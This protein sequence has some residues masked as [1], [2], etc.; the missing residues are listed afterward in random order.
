M[1]QTTIH[2]ST[3]RLWWWLMQAAYQGEPH[4]YNQQMWAWMRR[5]RSMTLDNRSVVVAS[6]AYRM[7]GTWT[8]D[9]A[10]VRSPRDG[11][12]A[13]RVI[14]VWKTL[15][16]QPVLAKATLSIGRYQWRELCDYAEQEQAESTRPGWDFLFES[17]WRRVGAYQRDQAGDADYYITSLAAA[18]DALDGVKFRVHPGWL[19]DALYMMRPTATIT[20][21]ADTV[22]VE[23]NDCFAIIQQQRPDKDK[24]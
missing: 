12:Y 16:S 22:I 24:S 20:V 11:L 10:I 19:K 21:Y 18:G 15:T 5:P 14:G 17:E 8:N 3:K 23:G 9:P 7:H 1:T 6:D 13:D 4:D 2:R